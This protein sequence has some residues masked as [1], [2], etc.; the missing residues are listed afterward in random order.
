MMWMS[1]IQSAE[2]LKIKDWDVPKKNCPQAGNIET[3]PGFLAW[4]PME[5]RPKAATSTLTWIS[6]PL[7]CPTDLGLACPHHHTVHFLKLLYVY[8]I[9]VPSLE[10]SNT[11]R[12]NT[13]DIMK[14]GDLKIKKI[15]KK[16]KVTSKFLEDWKQLQ[17]QKLAVIYR[18][19]VLPSKEF[20]S[21]EC[22]MVLVGGLYYI[23]VLSAIP[24]TFQW[25]GFFY[26]QYYTT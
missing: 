3:V 25:S 11:E 23:T 6:S 19:H 10:N 22:S 2:G 7:A 8:T 1:V 15:K 12:M 14:G 5:F 20:C 17:L 9:F 16:S 4:C 26:C 24:L 18:L 21:P 13:R